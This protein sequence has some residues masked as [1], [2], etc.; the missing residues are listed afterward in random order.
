MGYE[1]QRLVVNS[2]TI[3]F[4]SDYS[5]STMS[6]ENSFRIT[7]RM[8]DFS[9]LQTAADLQWPAF[10]DNT[11]GKPLNKTVKYSLVKVTVIRTQ[12]T[13]YDSYTKRK[14]TYY[15]CSTFESTVES[16]EKSFV[17]GEIAFP[18]IEV[19]GFEGW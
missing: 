15:E 9:K 19:S 16:G 12:K 7:A 4:N 11:N 3:Y 17:N 2:G 1:T 5:V 6:D 10:P 14:R 18:L 8:R 13:E